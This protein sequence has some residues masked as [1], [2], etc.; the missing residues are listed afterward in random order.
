MVLL[1]G[2]KATLWATGQQARRVLRSVQVP[3]S[4]PGDGDAIFHRAGEKETGAE[5]TPNSI[6][7]NFRCPT[8]STV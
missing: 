5:K 4:P 2:L 6:L 1:W 8:A 7:L 3:P